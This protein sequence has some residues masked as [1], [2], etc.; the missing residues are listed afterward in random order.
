MELL[1]AIC[2]TKWDANVYFHIRERFVY[3]FKEEDLDAVIRVHLKADPRRF[4]TKEAKFQAIQDH[5]ED[6]YEKFQRRNR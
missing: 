3:E 6:A 2:N 5:Y 4:L 1:T